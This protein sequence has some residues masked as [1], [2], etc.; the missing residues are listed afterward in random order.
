MKSRFSDPILSPDIK[1]DL[2]ISIIIQ[3]KKYCRGVGEKKNQLS[4]IYV[5]YTELV[6]YQHTLIN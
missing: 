4:S 2:W 5:I 1:N 6:H 3:F